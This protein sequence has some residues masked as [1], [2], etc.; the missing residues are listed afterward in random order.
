[1]SALD[2][3]SPRARAFPRLAALAAA[4]LAALTA[5]HIAVGTV[6]LSLGEVLRALAGRP[7]E[8]LHAKIVTGLRLPRALV[9]LLAG[10]MLGTAGALLQIVT[11]N[12]LA[13][14]GLLGVS[15]GAV[16]AIVLA[17][18]FG[19]GTET[20]VGLPV[21]GVA[22][23]LAAGLLAYLLSLDR[24]SDPVR[25]VLTGVLVAGMCT[26]L[27]AGLLL[28]ARETELLRIVR[29]TVGSTNGR[30]WA[31]LQT[32]LPY[33]AAGLPLAFASAGAANALQ[34]GDATARGLGQ[35]VEGAR[36][37]LLVVAAIL[38]AGAVA[39]VGAIGLIGLIGPHMARRFA[40][41]DARRLLPAAALVTAAL[42]LGADI[43]ARTLELAALGLLVG[44][45]LPEGAGLPVGAV[46]ALL[47]VPFFLWLL[48]RLGGPA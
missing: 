35:R 26:A 10:A 9:A 25:L 1:M 11:R 41:T 29:W 8:D 42:L 15:G 23:G 46:T 19:L 17:L 38:T 2:W 3:R 37:W 48:I 16:L 18:V 14:P 13:E 7:A 22:G 36:L 20:G 31:H 24:G 32:L 28:G 43:L 6:D 40:G 5:L 44:L 12:P 47:G 45:D 33:A 34:L 21:F 27:T 30:V 39:V 4:G